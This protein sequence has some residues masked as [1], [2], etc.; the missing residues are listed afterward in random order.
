[1]PEWRLR[2]PQAIC[3]DAFY[4]LLSLDCSCDTLSFYN[5]VKSV[6]SCV[7]LLHLRSFSNMPLPTWLVSS[8]PLVNSEPLLLDGGLSTQ[9]SNYVAGV[10]EDPLWT[11]RSVVTSPASVVRAHQDFVEAGVRVLLTTTYQIS[12]E[13]FKQ[14]LNLD[15][16]QTYRAVIDSVD[17]A[18]AAVKN[19]GKQA[20]HVLVGG[21]VGPYG[22]CQHDGSEYT[23]AYLDHI[24]REILTQWHRLRIQA[25]MASDV[26]FIAVETVPGS[27]EALAVLDCI[28]EDCC[29]S[30]PIWVSFTL[31]AENCSLPTGES[32]QD[33]VRKV[34]EHPLY[35]TSRVFAVG[36]NC[37]APRLV[38]DAL[39]QIR[40]VTHSLP[41]V[42]YPNSGE[43]WSGENSKWQGEPD[44]WH[45]YIKD[46]LELGALVI[47]GCCRVDAASV[48]AIRLSVTNLLADNF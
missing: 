24:S 13:G 11:A 41:L 22:A 28:A 5:A 23:G 39:R 45:D 9:L 2:Y 48:K 33:S 21:S 3:Y 34:C 43:T 31:N 44:S 17:L 29:N 1:M 7:T 42:V 37:C 6:S 27:L 15:S 16:S 40:L 14:H 32:L 30:T 8:P 36:V 26:D 25:L 46:W 18:R 38:T 12:P 35:K 20:S 10:D 4:C 19:A 47:G